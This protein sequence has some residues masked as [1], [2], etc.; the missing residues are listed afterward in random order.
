MLPS[1]ESLRKH[2]VR[3]VVGPIAF[4]GGIAAI[5]IAII[6]SAKPTAEE[7]RKAKLVECVKDTDD[8]DFCKELYGGK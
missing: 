7:A 5:V 8:V 3:E 2:L 4:V 6:L 1:K